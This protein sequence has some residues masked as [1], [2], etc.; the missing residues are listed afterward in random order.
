MDGVAGAH[1]AAEAD[2][3]PDVRA[4]GLQGARNAR[5]AERVTNVKACPFHGWRRHNEAYE[6]LAE[7]FYMR[8]TL[9]NV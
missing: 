8:S 7:S 5:M 2:A 9:E 4:S 1:R 3:V 6:V